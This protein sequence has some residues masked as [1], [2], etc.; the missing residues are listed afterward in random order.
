MAR[1]RYFCDLGSVPVALK[2]I[3]PMANE[4][5]AMR[6]PG[7]AGLRADGYTRWAGYP[8]DGA[9]GPLP[10]TRRIEYKVH[11]SLHECN[12]KCMNGKATGSCECRC[13]GSNHGR[14]LFTGLHA[15]SEPSTLVAND[16]P[17]YDHAQ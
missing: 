8:L 3:W 13:G 7:V 1:M 2:G 11:P 6:F 17:N 4:K 5:F 10:V 15:R 14:G 16:N 12:T 9:G